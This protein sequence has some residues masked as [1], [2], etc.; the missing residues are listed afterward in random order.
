MGAPSLGPKSWLGTEFINRNGKLVA[1][2]SDLPF[3]Q[4]TSFLLPSISVDEIAWRLIV[5]STTGALT[6]ALRMAR[7]ELEGPDVPSLA[8]LYLEMDI[9]TLEINRYIL[10]HCQ[11]NAIT[12]NTAKAICEP[13]IWRSM[14]R[15]P[16]YG[17]HRLCAFCCG[18]SQKI[19]NRIS[20]YAGMV[21]TENDLTPPCKEGDRGKIKPAFPKPFRHPTE[22]TEC[23][24]NVV[25]GEGESVFSHHLSFADK[26]NFRQFISNRMDF[27][28]VGFH[29]TDGEQNGDLNY[30]WH[31]HVVCMSTGP[32]VLEGPGYRDVKMRWCDYNILCSTFKV[33]LKL[34]NALNSCQPVKMGKMTE[35]LFPLSGVWHDL[36]NGRWNWGQACMCLQVLILMHGC[37]PRDLFVVHDKKVTNFQ[38]KRQLWF[39]LW[40]FMI[41][42]GVWRYHDTVYADDI[43]NDDLR[44]CQEW[45]EVGGW[46]KPY[47]GWTRVRTDEIS[48]RGVMFS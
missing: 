46:S 28:I 3:L 30:G 38:F 17:L 31:S 35:L 5:Y 27:V 48:D 37:L 23:I 21:R 9:N 41:G 36:D 25:E 47:G 16:F 6:A 33:I 43:R 2:T 4:V 42:K 22:R 26:C 45:L 39:A 10:A 32:M 14:M 40:Q 7:D 8:E 24:W 44:I 20:S 12:I 11:D 18:I 13:L 15:A 34:N 19:S 1:K 29:I